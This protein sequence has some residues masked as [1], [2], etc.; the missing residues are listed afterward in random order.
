MQ[1]EG[2]AYGK[3][4]V[5]DS[6]QQIEVEALAVRDDTRRG[7]GLDARL[8]AASGRGMDLGEA[9]SIFSQMLAALDY[10]RRGE[11]VPD[12]IMLGLIEERDVGTRELG[13]SAGVD[14]AD[15]AS[16]SGAETGSDA[17]NACNSRTTSSIVGEKTDSL[18]LRPAG[19]PPQP[20]MIRSAS[21][22]AAS[23][24]MPS[25]ARRPMRTTVLMRT[26][27]GAN[28]STRWSSRRA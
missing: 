9:L 20:K 14:G 16:P 28:S 24:T 22:S 13:H 10:M 7:Q 19:L 2:H 12:G 8:Q 26:P 5:R 6:G 15:G 25:A 4:T 17:R 1:A 23:S 27:S 21:S 18:P 3:A 11:L